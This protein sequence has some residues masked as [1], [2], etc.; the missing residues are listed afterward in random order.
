MILSAVKRYYK[1]L[2]TGSSASVLWIG[3][4]V[5]ATLLSFAYLVTLKWQLPLAQL[6]SYSA[7]LSPQAMVTK[8]ILL[9][10]SG[11]AFFCGGL[12]A[13]V[14]IL[15]QQVVKNNLASDSTLAVGSGALLAMVLAILFFPSLAIYG[16]FWVAFVGAL[17]TL[18]LVVVI[19][20][21]SKLDPLVLIIAGFVV[22]IFASSFIGLMV[23][24]DTEYYTR[25]TLWR[26]G[27]LY[28][29]RW[30]PLQHLM[31]ASLLTLP[32]LLFFHKPLML[33][34]LDDEQ[35]ARLGLR[36]SWL[37]VAIFVLCAVLTALVV[38]KVGMIGFVGLGA[39]TMVNAMQIRH[40]NLRIVVGFVLGG[41]LLL[42]TNNL[43]NILTHFIGLSFPLPAG[44]L[45]GLL[46]A[47]LIIWLILKQRKQPD[48]KDAYNIVIAPKKIDWWLYSGSLLFLFVY[49]LLFA[50]TA[51]GWQFTFD[52]NHIMQFRL[53]RSL[54]AASTGVMLAI[55]GVVLQQMTRNPM[56]S[57]EV[58]GISSAASITMVMAFLLIPGLSL[59]SVIG[60]GVLG[61]LVTLIIILWLA[62]KVHSSY[63][64]LIGIAIGALVSAFD[65][66][67][68]FSQDPRLQAILS[69]LSG[70]TYHIMP[71]L[72]YVLLALAIVTYLLS[73]LTIKPLKL[74]TLTEPVAKGRGLSVKAVQA[75]LL[76]FVAV[77]ST[78]A[79]VTVGPLSF[80]GLMVP[81]LA[82]SLGAVQVDKQLALSALLGALVML[83]A[84]W[85]GRYA[86]Y[87]YEIPVGILASLIGGGYFLI[88]MRKFNKRG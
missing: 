59:V 7:Q 50:Q 8:L 72:A 68:G 51:Y 62:T 87:P 84:D 75:G 56:A 4:F 76:V 26:S 9:A 31:I 29:I 65:V 77:L 39:A 11:M 33:M 63:L 83:I 25:L 69:W 66:I 85:V 3:V 70:T 61:S 52:L 36:V 49:C 30:Q 13:V 34:A 57:P 48:T 21:P 55:A 81:Q 43:I 47:P 64:L 79:T 6:F 1:P 54:G 27:L 2:I 19:A 74:L 40:I 44:T 42:L 88:M 53:G 15:L 58:L 32:L 22:S 78:L 71:Q 28:Q 80:I 46:G 23:I 10:E 67:I 82:R 41:L 24:F 86:I 18:A 60:F 16:S 14:S 37:R 73:L 45:T 35:A 38:S 20:L 5:L 12:L 17:V